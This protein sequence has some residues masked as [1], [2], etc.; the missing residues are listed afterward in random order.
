MTIPKTPPPLRPTIPGDRDHERLDRALEE[1]VKD[2][3]IDD[4]IERLNCTIGEKMTR[5]L[6]VACGRSLDDLQAGA[7]NAM[8][9]L[10]VMAAKNALEWPK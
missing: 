10:P 4:F 1:P 8:R 2:E 5:S 6:P 3:W 7:E 9:E